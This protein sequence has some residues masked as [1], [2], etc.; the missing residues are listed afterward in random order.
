MAIILD[1]PVNIYTCGLRL[2]PLQS[3]CEP[4][5]AAVEFGY[6]QHAI[7][8]AVAFSQKLSPLTIRSLRIQTLKI[9]LIKAL[10]RFCSWLA[11]SV[12]A[13]LATAV[14]T[15]MAWLPTESRKVTAVNLSLCLPELSPLHRQH[16]VKASLIET[17]KTAFE[18]G[19]AWQAPAAKILSR[20]VCISGHEVMSEALALNKGVIIVAPHLG[21]WEICGTYLATLGPITFMYKPQKAEEFDR[22]VRK[23][24]S[25]MGGALAPTNRKGVMM[26]VQAL[27][28]GEILGIL[29]D[30]EPKMDGG[31]FAPFFGVNALT[32]T[33]VSKLAARTGATVVSVFAKRLPASAG[34]EIVFGRASLGVDSTDPVA[35][36]SALNQLVEDCVRQAPTQYQWEYK[37]FNR[38]PD[39]SKNPIYS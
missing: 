22:F 25:R 35:A 20:L 30:Q 14:G 9:L 29:P 1:S 24:R 31:V 39:G 28:R 23:S 11:P 13:M 19:F 17:A 16:M 37:R 21:N 6:G 15:V 12:T 8:R 27:E 2:K 18:L 26:A 5:Q 38:L 3:F 10:L 33:L 34:F 4:S 32:M 7:V 36:A